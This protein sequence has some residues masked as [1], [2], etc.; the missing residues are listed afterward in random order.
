MT[1]FTG[2]LGLLCLVALASLM[3]AIALSSRAHAGECTNYDQ[4]VAEIERQGAKLFFIAPARLPKT[5]A[6]AEAITGETYGVAERG[7]LIVGSVN[8]VLGLEVGGCLL[9]PIF[10]RNPRPDG[11]A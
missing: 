5:V 9:D 11:A 8:T 4:T 10:I 7:F 6:D 3:F 1:R 2:Y